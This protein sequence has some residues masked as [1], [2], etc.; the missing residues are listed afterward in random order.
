MSRQ[1]KLM[2]TAVLSLACAVPAVAQ[3]RAGQ[4]S[5][6]NP[7]PAFKDLPGVVPEAA[8]VKQ[9]DAES[10]DCTTATQYRRWRSGDAFPDFPVQVYRCEKN[11]IVYS[12][13]NMPDRPWVPG[14]NPVELP[15]E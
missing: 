5:W 4:P 9:K 14:L 7:A 1:M 13:R 15:R 12:G 8:R 2:I 11:G 6:G 3:E 10:A